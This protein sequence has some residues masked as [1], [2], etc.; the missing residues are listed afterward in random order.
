MTE[1]DE[2]ELDELEKEHNYGLMHNLGGL[3]KKGRKRAKHL[4]EKIKYEKEGR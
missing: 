4:S 1:E 3:D 2:K